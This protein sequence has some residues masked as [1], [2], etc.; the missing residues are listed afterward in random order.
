M[1]VRP[2]W[3][4]RVRSSPRTRFWY[5]LG[6]GVLGIALMVIAPFTGVLPG[7]G[8]I[9]IFLLGVALLATE[10]VWAKSLKASFG[11]GYTRY[12]AL[13]RSGRAWVWVAFGLVLGLFWWLTLVLTGVPGW[14]PDWAGRLL[15][16]LPGVR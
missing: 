11:R 1:T 2:T 10:F 16:V 12:L 4:A 9:P 13:S 15:I 7:P 6:V 8:G 3:R 14:L 5:R